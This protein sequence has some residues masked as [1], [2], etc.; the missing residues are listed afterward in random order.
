MSSGDAIKKFQK[1]DKR[2]PRDPFKLLQKLDTVS[3]RFFHTTSKIR[4]KGSRRFSN[5]FKNKR[6][7]GDSFKLLQE[8]LEILSNYFKNRTQGIHKILLNHF[9]NQTQ[10]DLEILLNYFKNQT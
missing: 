4:H 2:S 3:S 10:R 7:S 6:S 1:P 5:Y 9:K 8:T